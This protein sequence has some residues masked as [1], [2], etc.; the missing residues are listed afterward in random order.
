MSICDWPAA[1]RPREKLL[2]QGAGCLSDAELLAIFLRT[3]IKGV[4][5]VDMARR[6]MTEFGSLSRLLSADL[7]EFE[8][9]HGLGVAKYTQL[10]A[11]KELVRR[12]LA[13]EMKL[14][15]A[16]SSPQAVRD[17]LRLTIGL[18]D[19]EVFV[20]IFLTAQNRVLA[21]EEVFSGTLSETRVYPRE[22]VR[23]ALA[24]N[25]AG[26]IVAHNHPSGVAEPSSADRALTDTLKAALQL[27]DVRLLDHFVITG[28]HAESF[29]ERGWL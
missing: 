2:A 25:A 5:A 8:R 12:A 26:V 20:V 1:E 7:A 10:M 23:R 16:L 13:E 14:A 22:V 21:V 24:H 29:A 4:S 6:L 27:V 9:Q 17:F 3:G 28:S 15:D 18:R 11:T 19:V